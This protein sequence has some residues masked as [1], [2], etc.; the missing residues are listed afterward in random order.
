MRKDRPK[1]VAA[2]KGAITVNWRIVQ[3]PMRLV[4]YVVHEL[5]H[6]VHK[7]HTKESRVRPS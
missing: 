5:V 4:D 1:L 3:A 6:L 7:N 2:V